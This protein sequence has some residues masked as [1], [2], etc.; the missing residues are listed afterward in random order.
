MAK[1][2]REMVEKAGV[3]RERFGVRIQ[4]LAADAIAD[5]NLGSRNLKREWLFALRYFSRL[6]CVYGCVWRPWS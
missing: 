3:N 6:T 4:N 5:W 1:V 2:A